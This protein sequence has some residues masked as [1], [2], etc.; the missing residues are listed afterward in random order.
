[1]I[2][3][4]TTQS[5][6]QL[7]LPARVDSASVVHL[8]AHIQDTFGSVTESPLSSVSVRPNFTAIEDLINKLEQSNSPFKFKLTD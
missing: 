3:A 1:M 7:R 4:R 5:T 2:I 8:V 6:L